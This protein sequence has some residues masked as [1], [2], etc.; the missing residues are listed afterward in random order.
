ME[1]QEMEQKVREVLSD[2]AFV[3]RLAEMEEPEQVRAALAEKGI[4]LSV[5]DIVKLRDLLIRAQENGGE[6]T[7]DDLAEVAGG[8]PILFVVLIAIV[9]LAAVAV[10][11][12]N[13]ASSSRR[14]W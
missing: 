8:M 12:Y 14:R 4:D 3:K 6:L 7:E 9:E 2:E 1:Q 11:A 13:I 10:C 5:E